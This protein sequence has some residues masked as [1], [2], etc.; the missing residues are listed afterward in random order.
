[1][2]KAHKNKHFDGTR[3]D[4]VYAPKESHRPAII[5]EVQRQINQELMTRVLRHYASIY[6]LYATLP[7]I[8]LKC[9]GNLPIPK[10]HMNSPRMCYS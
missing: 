10:L 7:I 9:I 1:M 3:S 6:E 5:V 8:F 4:V 2:K